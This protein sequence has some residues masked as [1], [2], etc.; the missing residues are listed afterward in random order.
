MLLERGAA[1]VCTGARDPTSIRTPDVV[2][3]R[4]DITSQADI[5]AAAD[6]CGDV[7]LLVNDAEI[8]TGASRLSK[9]AR[10]VPPRIRHERVRPARSHP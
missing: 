3:V 2:P 6:R 10:E 8:S 4:L 1:T 5:S 9:A 7:T